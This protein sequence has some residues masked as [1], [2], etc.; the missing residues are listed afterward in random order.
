MTYS[1]ELLSDQ[2]VLIGTIHEQFSLKDDFEAYLN[3]LASTLDN[4]D[5]PV[6]Y[7]ND[8]RNLKVKVFQ[9]LLVATN[10]GTRGGMAIT[11]HPN[12]DLVILVTSD[13][14]VQL[15]VKGLNSDIFGNLN[16]P[17][18]ETLGEALAHAHELVAHG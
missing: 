12:I 13:K 5:Q 7:I 9:D 2:P 18:F 16:Y 8:T 17:V 6:F 14:L 3:E 15:M 1:F 10:Q 11:Q 4:V